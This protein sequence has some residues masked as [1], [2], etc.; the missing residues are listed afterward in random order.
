MTFEG[1]ADIWA[2]WAGW[3]IGGAGQPHMSAPRPPLLCGVFPSLLE[4]SGVVFTADK[5]VFI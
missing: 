1:G 2:Q 4:P 3:L 5:R